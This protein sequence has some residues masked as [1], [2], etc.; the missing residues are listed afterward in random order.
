MQEKILQNAKVLYDFHNQNRTTIS[1]DF[2]LIMGSHDLRVANHAAS[3]F[4]QGK[5]PF[6]VCSGGYGKITKS[7]WNNTEAETYA[8]ICIE[9]GVP[10][11]KILIENKST[12]SG[13][14]FNFTK[15]LLESRNIKVSTGTIVCKNYLSRRALA[16]AKKQWP[17]VEWFIETPNL[18]FD[19]YIKNESNI[20]R[21]IN[22]LVG[23]IQRLMIYPNF[24]FQIPVTI[25]QEILNSYDFLVKHGY[26]QFLIDENNS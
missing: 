13:E 1:T 9:N 10:K 24:G 4:L 25:P 23:D 3:L 11:D 17:E 15:K 8:Q 12:N 18:S 6:L 19:E 14:N 2:M 26:T 5:A 7:L 22:L 16:T 21:M 20:D